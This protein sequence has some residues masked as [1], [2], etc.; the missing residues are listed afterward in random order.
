MWRGTLCRR[1]RSWL[2]LRYSRGGKGVGRRREV[3]GRRKE[4][5]RK[6]EEGGRRREEGGRK[7]EGGRRK[8]HPLT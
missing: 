3:P 1:L 7:E 8:A 2:P 6:E 4:G 5:G